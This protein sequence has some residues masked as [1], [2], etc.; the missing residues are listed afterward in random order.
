MRSS[1]SCRQAVEHAAD[2][3]FPGRRLRGPTLCSFGL[4]A[5]LEIVD[6]S[7]QHF[8]GALRVAVCFVSLSEMMANHPQSGVVGVGACDGLLQVTHRSAIDS[9]LEEH[10]AE[11][12]RRIG[13]VWQQRLGVLRQ[14]EGAIEILARVGQQVGEI[15]L[16]ECVIVV[17]LDGVFIRLLSH[18]ELTLGF[19]EQ[20][21]E[22]MQARRSRLHLDSFLVGRNGLIGAASQ[23][24]EAR[25][26]LMHVDIVGDQL[27]G[28]NE[29][30]F[31]PFQ[32]T[33]AE[34]NHSVE[35]DEVGVSG[36]RLG[37][38]NDE[39]LGLGEVLFATPVELE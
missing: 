29:L 26:L 11:G 22:V 20:R 3:T 23:R 18:I 37:R 35:L 12:V 34:Q 6:R 7:S 19:V 33:V 28:E 27:R 8:C 14:I 1:A 13:I 36:V 5:L 15:I 17:V 21:E 9:T 24:V 32:V 10:P 2:F 38:R 31:C 16:R 4:V 39:L 30:G 25:Q